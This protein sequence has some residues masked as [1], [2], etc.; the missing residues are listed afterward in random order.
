MPHLRM[1]RGFSTS[2]KARDGI[3]H[4]GLEHIV[5]IHQQRGI[6]GIDLAVGLECLILLSNIWTQEWAMVPP[7]GTPYSWSEIVQ[8][9]PA[10]PPI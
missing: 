3:R 5:G 6:V 7:A 9:V 1:P 2:S 4:A 10:Q 8:A